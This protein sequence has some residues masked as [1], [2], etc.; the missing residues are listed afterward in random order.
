MLTNDHEPSR[1][2]DGLGDFM[3]DGTSRKVEKDKRLTENCVGSPSAF[4]N[5]SRMGSHVPRS[6][7]YLRMDWCEK[8]VESVGK[9]YVQKGAEY[10]EDHDN[11][12]SDG[13]EGMLGPADGDVHDLNSSIRL[14]QPFSRKNDKMYS[15]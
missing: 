11:E 5:V 4:T 8:N 13:K 14:D 12:E 15:Q 10:C 6:A 9:I 2:W 3:K 1:C 7:K